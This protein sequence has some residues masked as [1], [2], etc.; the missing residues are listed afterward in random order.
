MVNLLG[1]CCWRWHPLSAYKKG[2]KIEFSIGMRD[3]NFKEW[4]YL[5]VYVILVNFGV[6]FIFI[7]IVFVEV[8]GLYILS[9]SAYGSEVSI[10]STYL[11][12]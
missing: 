11:T 10:F 9:R 12:Q 2:I 1:V 8:V 4:G 7:I 6:G 5:G 3:G